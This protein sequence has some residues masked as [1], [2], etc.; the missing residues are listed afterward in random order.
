MTPATARAMHIYFHTQDCSHRAHR[1]HTRELAMCTSAR[2]FP[3]L[4]TCCPSP[5][6]AE[7]REHNKSSWAT[8][9][10]YSLSLAK[11]SVSNTNPIPIQHR[12]LAG[13]TSE[14]GFLDNLRALA[15]P[16]LPWAGPALQPPWCSGDARA[17]IP[18]QE[19]FDEAGDLG[20][21]WESGAKKSPHCSATHPSWG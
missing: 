9:Q 13:H 10:A 5:A 19:P 17:S 11:E 3:G 21:A 14:Y 7:F 12:G 2:V 20:T 18:K 1:L 6:R 16:I 8:S 15:V 4:H